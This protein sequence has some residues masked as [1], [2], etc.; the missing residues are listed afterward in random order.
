MNVYGYVLVVCHCFTITTISPEVYECV[1]IC[2]TDE[3]ILYC[4]KNGIYI[5]ENKKML[6]SKY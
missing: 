3:V 6:I 2:H 4:H 5:L 1:C